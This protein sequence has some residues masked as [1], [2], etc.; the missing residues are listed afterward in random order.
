MN[1]EKILSRLH[2]VKK[3]GSSN[4]ICKCPSHVDKSPSL[5]ISLD[6]RNGN[7]LMTCFAGCDTY[8]ILQSIGCDWADVFPDG[9]GIQRD[10]PKAKSVIYATEA[11]ELV[12]FESQIVTACAMAI[13]RGEVLQV[14]DFERLDKAMQTINKAYQ[15]A[16]L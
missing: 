15:A 16:G 1:L 6:S 14:E 2:G 10:Y 5:S 4:W 11:L 7:L 8:S 12:R 13:K 9:N 3:T